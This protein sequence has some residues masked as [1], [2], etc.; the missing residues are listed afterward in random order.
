VQ[1]QHS[2]EQLERR[3]LLGQEQHHDL[4]VRDGPYFSPLVSI[5]F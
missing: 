3:R 2:I 5:I 1:H 4:A